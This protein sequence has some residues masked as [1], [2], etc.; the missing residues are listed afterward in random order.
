MK[1]FFTLIAAMA[2]TLTAAATDY[3]DKLSITIEG[4]EEA[5]ESTTTISIDKQADG[6]YT[7]ML[8]QFSFMGSILVGDVTMTDVEGVTDENG[9]TNYATTQTATITNGA[10]IAAMLGGKIDVTL[11]KGSR[12]KDGKFY[13]VIDLEVIGVGNV[14]AVF[15]DNNFD[16]TGINTMNGTNGDKVSAIYTL[17]GARVNTMVRGINILKM[18]SGKT[19]KVMNK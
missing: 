17:G 2:L 16:A 5:A 1:K 14:H 3:T 10:E 11:Q 7:I 15:G 13:A 8:K 19:I 6:K 18:Q 12:S 4:E 9:F